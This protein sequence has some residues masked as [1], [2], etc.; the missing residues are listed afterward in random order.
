MRQPNPPSKAPESEDRYAWSYEAHAER[1]ARLGLKLSP[2]ER[3]RWL[4]ETNAA[5]R[6]LLGRAR[7]SSPTST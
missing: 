7:C 5:M 4:E 3:L 2:A 1:Q 6:A